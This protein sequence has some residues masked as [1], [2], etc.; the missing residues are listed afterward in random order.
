MS[1]L[2]AFGVEIP[3]VT[4]AWTPP[5]ERALSDY[6]ALI[7]LPSR[8]HIPYPMVKDIILAPGHTRENIHHWLC[9][10]GRMGVSPYVRD[11]RYFY[12]GPCRE[13]LGSVYH[14]SYFRCKVHRPIT[15]KEDRSKFEELCRIL[16]EDRPEALQLVRAYDP[17]DQ[18]CRRF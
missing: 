6:Y 1:D 18:Y 2:T 12:C 11:G 13:E 4:R 8:R 16:E 5:G 3:P 10:K 9:I 14:G 17:H 7:E 15:V